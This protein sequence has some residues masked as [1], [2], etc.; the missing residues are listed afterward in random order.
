MYSPYSVTLS[1][2]YFVIVVFVT[3]TRFA[4]PRR[5]RRCRHQHKRQHQLPDK[6]K[7]MLD[8]LLYHQS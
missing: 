2:Y 8:F 5:C 6:G 4:R 3:E 7:V 1:N